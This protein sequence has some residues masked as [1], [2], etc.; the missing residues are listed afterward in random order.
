MIPVDANAGGH[1]AH[2]RRAASERRKAA[3][4]RRGTTALALKIA[5]P[6]A[7]KQKKPSS[8]A[9]AALPRSGARAIWI[10]SIG[11]FG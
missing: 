10:A 8:Q 1:A 6:G 2:R 9:M 4:S 5:I 7:A 11:G 3:A